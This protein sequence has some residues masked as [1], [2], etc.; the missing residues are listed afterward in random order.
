[1]TNKAMRAAIK[2]AG[3]NVRLAQGQAGLW[4][5]FLTPSSGSAKECWFDRI[6]GTQSDALKAALVAATE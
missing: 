3:Y 5:V 1:M 2:N 6:P 4:N